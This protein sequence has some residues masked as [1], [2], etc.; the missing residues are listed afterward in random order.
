MRTRISLLGVLLLGLALLSLCAF[1]PLPACAATLADAAETSSQGTTTVTHAIHKE[2]KLTDRQ[3]LYVFE[4]LREALARTE[5]EYGPAELVR[6]EL[7]VPKTRQR[8]DL[9]SPAGPKLIDV[10][11]TSSSL[12]KEEQFLPVRIPLLKGVLGYRVFLIDTHRA[13][14]FADIKTL[15]DLKQFS[16]GQGQGWSDIEILEHNG[17]KVV[18]GDPATLHPM[19]C[20]GRFD[21]F[22]RGINEAPRELGHHAEEA[23]CLALEPKLALYYPFVRYF[24]FSRHT[25]KGRTLAERVELGLTRLIADGT[26]DK[27]FHAYIAPILDA[28]DLKGRTLIRLENPFVGKDVPQDRPELWF[29]PLR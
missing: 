13:A 10:L 4:L 23:P 27:R 18:T 8:L 24:F 12:E 9:A 14:E 5:A 22:S 21:L 7:L 16:I 20:L 25:E 28:I 26:F 1:S 19:L 6:Y 11:Y 17:L 29:D 3:Y 15:G 2:S